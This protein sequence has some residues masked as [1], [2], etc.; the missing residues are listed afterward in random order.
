MS[1]SYAKKMAQ[2]SARIFGELIVNKNSPN[3]RI[4]QRLSQ[5]PIEKIDEY[6]MNY[7]PRHLENDHLL[8]VARTYG[9][10]RLFSSLI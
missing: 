6:S 9:L 1:S 2:L 5:K 3:G 8:K 10:Y 7:Y 4:I